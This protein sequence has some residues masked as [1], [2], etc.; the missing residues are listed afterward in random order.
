VQLVHARAGCPAELAAAGP[1]SCCEP[2]SAAAHGTHNEAARAQAPHTHGSGRQRHL[3]TISVTENTPHSTPAAA[4]KVATSWVLRI[5][6]GPSLI[7]V[8]SRMESQGSLSENLVGDTNS[9]PVFDLLLL[10]IIEER[11]SRY[12]SGGARTP[13]GVCGFAPPRRSVVARC[14]GTSN[15]MRRPA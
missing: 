13:L 7:G 2:A 8:F 9:G 15:T 14:V 3:D 1:F 5:V 6:C 12:R 4:T 10:V 11:G